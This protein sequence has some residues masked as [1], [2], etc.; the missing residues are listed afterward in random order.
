MKIGSY[1]HN[2]TSSTIVGILNVTPDSFSDGGCFNN[3]ADAINYALELA[4]AGADII[5][6]GGES[7]R[8]NS[9]P[10]SVDE[11][12]GRVLPVIKGIRQQSDIPI[13]IDTSKACV[14]TQ[15]LELGADMI[16]DISAGTFDQNMFAVAA[17]YQVPICLMH[18]RGTP[19]TMQNNLAYANIFAEIADFLN[20][21]S[22]QAIQA[23]V[24]AD[25]IILDPGIG[26]GKSAQANLDLLR[27]LNFFKE[28]GFPLLIGTSRK[29]FIG[30][31]LG[32]ELSDRLEASLASISHAKLRGAEFFR[33]H[34][35]AASKRYL[36]MV[37]LLN[38]PD[39]V[40]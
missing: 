9:Q 20:T 30:N 19:Q 16:N 34:D 11:E 40:K 21:A 4:K 1:I 32:H 29:S 18:M 5:D 22:V 17:K 28:L 31:L 7:T 2:S 36:A 33:V 27:Q 37:D 14:A 39:G 6:I 23:G 12:L 26:F 13:S 8:P 24:S 10:V 3:P 38:Q 25:N 35:V 15:A